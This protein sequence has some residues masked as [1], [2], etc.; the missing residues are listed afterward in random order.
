[1]IT[2]WQ[3]S[4]TTKNCMFLQKLMTD[5][6]QNRRGG[7]QEV[8][9]NIKGAAGI[10]RKRWLC[11]KNQKQRRHGEGVS[12]SASASCFWLFLLQPLPNSPPLFGTKPSGQKE[13]LP[14]NWTKT[15]TTSS[16]INK[17]RGFTKRRLKREGLVKMCQD[18]T[19]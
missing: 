7:F 13:F 11:T 5:E 18:A 19:K 6:I 9:R 16:H 2:I 14:F 1:M 10:S 15:Q 4:D 12:V 8:P 3:K 17:K